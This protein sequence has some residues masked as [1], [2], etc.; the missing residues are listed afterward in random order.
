MVCN[1]TKNIEAEILDF[2]KGRGIIR[3]QDFVSKKWTRMHLQRL[4]EKGQIKKIGRGL[5]SSIN[6]VITEN[7]SL[8]EVAK[9]APN[10]VICLISA[11]QFYN[12]T[13]QIPSQIWIAVDI[14]AA[15]PKIAYPP[16]KI[17]NMTGRSLNDGIK[18]YEIEG[19]PVKVF[20]PA[21]TVA[22]C[23]KFR[24][25]IGLDVAIEA[26]RDSLEKKQATYDEIWKY[27]G[28]CRVRRVMQPYMEALA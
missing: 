16:I 17:I 9:L 27:A 15:R 4:V 3:P 14:K 19:V 22:D 20:S 5:Y 12:L 10:S 11:L 2:I 21:K 6:S 28:I 23:F 18:Q 26:L 1:V 13:T 7:H 25:K 8:A 24:N